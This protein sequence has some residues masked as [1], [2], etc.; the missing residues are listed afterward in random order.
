[1]LTKYPQLKEK[2]ITKD[3]KQTPLMRATFNCSI[4][5]VNFLIKE[6]V[7]VNAVSPKGQT[8]LSYAVKKNKLQIV[9]TLIQN[10]ANPNI[11]NN[12]G[13]TILDYAILP[14]FYNIALYIYERL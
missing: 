10:G 2:P 5:M 14:G 8:A 13:L 9:K 12:N 1:M 6:G 11:V 4:D 7:D 3:T